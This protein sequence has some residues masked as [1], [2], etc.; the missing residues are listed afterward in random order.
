MEVGWHYTVN[1]N[2]VQ[3]FLG[4]KPAE[5]VSSNINFENRLPN[6]KIYGKGNIL[7]CGQACT[8]L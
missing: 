2:A 6:V 3:K 1:T 7:P 4:P 5:W 8:S